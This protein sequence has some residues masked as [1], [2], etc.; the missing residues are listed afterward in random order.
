MKEQGRAAREDVADAILE[1]VP[2][3]MR[4]IRG[5]MRPGRGAA[6]SIPS[7]AA[8]RLLIY[9]RRH[10]GTSLSPVAEHLGVSLPAAS[11]LAERLVQAGLVSR[12]S[13]ARERRKVE[14]RLTSAG[15]AA[16][17]E[18]DERTRAWLRDRL[19]GLE[20]RRLARLLEALT[21]LRTALAEDGG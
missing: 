12:T 5:Q 14:L 18:R 9:L 7:V 19:A 21:D 16:L 13:N 8:F 6:G 10:P 2:A 11:Q 17:A 15:L 20:E 4:A 3:A 1:T